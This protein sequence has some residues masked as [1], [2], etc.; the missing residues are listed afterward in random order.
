MIKIIVIDD[1]DYVRGTTK[2]MLEVLGY[3]VFEIN[4]PAEI[5]P[6]MI[7][8]ICPDLIICDFNMPG[9]NGLQVFETIVKVFP[10]TRFLILSGG[11][12]SDQKNRA[13]FLEAEQIGLTI[14]HK[15]VSM[16]DLKKAIETA[17][18]F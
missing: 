5:N 2:E 6:E 1:D 11:P 12:G 9:K 10:K 18:M 15:P 7:E 3:E 17:L 8:D 13:D 14:L 16:A 4:N